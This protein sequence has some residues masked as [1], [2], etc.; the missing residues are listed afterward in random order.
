MKDY[1]KNKKTKITKL[2]YTSQDITH[3]DNRI[4]LCMWKDGD[5]D[6]MTDAQW[7]TGDYIDLDRLNKQINK[8]VCKYKLDKIELKYPDGTD[9]FDHY[10][11]F[12]K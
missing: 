5:L 2:L 9:D 12:E 3:E 10:L 1:L 11:I 4:E 6:D 8:L 7:Y